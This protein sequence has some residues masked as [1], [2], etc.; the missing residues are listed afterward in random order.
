MSVLPAECTHLTSL[1]KERKRT[2]RTA[3]FPLMS[4]RQQMKPGGVLLLKSPVL[5]AYSSEHMLHISL[6]FLIFYLPFR[7]IS[8]VRL[9]GPSVAPF[10]RPEK[11][12][13]CVRSFPREADMFRLKKGF[14]QC[15]SLSPDAQYNLQFGNCPM[16]YPR[17][18]CSAP[19]SSQKTATA[20]SA[21]PF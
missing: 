13:K 17:A 10:K 18:A 8:P 4:L 12:C 9:L 14:T 2:D 11:V 19:S 15:F 5:L 1:L 20:M 16:E 7:K 21:A 6:S 3:S